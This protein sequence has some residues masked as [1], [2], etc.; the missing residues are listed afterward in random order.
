MFSRNLRTT[1]SFSARK[2]VSRSMSKMVR[3]DG[4]RV[5]IACQIPQP[6][7]DALK[8]A[9][10][11][12]DLRDEAQACSAKELHDLV[13]GKDYECL[14]VTLNDKV[15]G[16]LLDA[17]GPKLKVVSTMSVGFDHVN[18]EEIKKRGLVAG[19]TPEVLTET[20]AEL[21]FS[22]MLATAR[23]I[24]EAVNAVKNGEWGSWVPLWMCG[25]DVHGSTVGIVGCG[26]I[27]KAFARRLLGFDLKACLYTDAVRLPE[28]EE[29]RLNLTFT[30]MD[31]LLARSD[32]VVP[33][34][35]LLP[36]TTK[37]FNADVFKKMKKTAIFI[38]TTRGPV[39]D[40]DALVH[41]LQTGEILAAG[42]DVTTPEPL[43]P[44]H[45][46]NNLPNCVVLPHI[47]SATMQTRGDMAALAAANAIAGIS[48]K[49]LP[50]QI[51]V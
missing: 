24:P 27:G 6:G 8:A 1:L 44:S 51:P 48:G 15:D 2:L 20:T 49:P 19:N 23:R 28:E 35:P 10:I 9:G 3:Q 32:F 33:H 31:D 22:L 17:A 16:D 4:A 43:P 34:C 11:P 42:L 45:P 26:R 29:K 40:Q 13:R 36:E 18:R 21:C 46:L 37:M 39:V 41:A 38:N 25:Q 12:F 47:A 7:Y 30:T 50:K 14:L 5:F